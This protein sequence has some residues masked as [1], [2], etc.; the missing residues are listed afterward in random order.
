M[1]GT[2]LSAIEDS[3]ATLTF[4]NPERQNSM[5]LQMWQDAAARLER[6]A[7]DESVRVVVLTG[8]GTKSFASGAD[9]SEFE[10]LRADAQAAAMYDQSLNRFWKALGEQP[11]PTIAMIRGYCIGG[12]LNIAAL[13]DLRI[14]GAGSKFA[15]PAAK[16]GLGYGAATMRRLVELVGPQF[17]MEILLTARQFSAA[18]AYEMGLVNRVVPDDEVENYTREMVEGIR[19]NAPLTI[20]AAK[21]IVRELMKDPAERDLAAGEAMVKQC[22][23]SMDYREGRLA[24]LQKRKP[25]FTGR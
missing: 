1:S 4:H 16:L 25:V 22:F 23:D 12:G 18:E 9:I 19:R 6:F 11:H 21:R 14:C 20:R 3:V 24:F 7:E 8:A 2:I 13:C 5:S 10:R 17:A 15:I